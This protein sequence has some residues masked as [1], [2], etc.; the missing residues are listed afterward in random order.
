M[1]D[2]KK[3]QLPIPG[4]L[5]SLCVLG[6]LW[7]NI[8]ASMGLIEQTTLITNLLYI[9]TLYYIAACIVLTIIIALAT[10]MILSD[11]KQGEELLK[12]LSKEKP[13]TFTFWRTM[14]YITFGFVVFY[15]NGLL[16]ITSMLI[17]FSLAT[18]IRA[19]QKHVYKTSQEI[20][21]TKPQ[22][23]DELKATR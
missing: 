7:A 14:Y 9:S 3:K 20:T 10:V 23:P 1:T 15:I 5:V 8:V 17:C 18:I 2:T 6:P 22:I 13:K 21:E 16:L 12:I 4:W 19:F 11:S